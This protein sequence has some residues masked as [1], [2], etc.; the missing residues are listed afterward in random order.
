M[1]KPLA[2]LWRLALAAAVSIVLLIGIANVI[3][4]PVAF[5]TGTYRA[6]FTDVSGLHEKD[7]VRVRGV[8]VGKVEAL[9]L[10]RSEGRSLAE[11]RFTMDTRFSVVPTSRLAIKFQ[12]LTGL[13]YV[14]VTGAAEGAATVNRMTT[15][16]TTMTQP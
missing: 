11:V 13:R 16:P 3:T 12:A 14:D 1:K 5:S 9:R 2:A 7:D 8:R 10:K 15:V 4:Q 6:E